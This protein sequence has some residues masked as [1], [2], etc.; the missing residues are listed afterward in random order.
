MAGYE[1]V[2]IALAGTYGEATYEVG[3]RPLLAM[4]RAERLSWGRE[5]GREVRALVRT[6]PKA[7]EA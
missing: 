5:G 1:D 4:P 7:E 3:R 6:G 2:L